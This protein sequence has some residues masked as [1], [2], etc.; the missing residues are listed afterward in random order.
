MHFKY[1]FATLKASRAALMFSQCPNSREKRTSCGRW[2]G[3]SHLPPPPPPPPPAA[4]G[5]GSVRRRPSPVP[6]RA[7][8]VRYKVTDPRSLSASW[9]YYSSSSTSSSS[10]E[11]S[12]RRRRHATHTA[13][14]VHHTRA[15]QGTRAATARR[16]SPVVCT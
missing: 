2:E 13:M 14:R 7:A 1:F 10:Y 9:T 3:E 15:Q 4:R 12:A 5:E 16:R 6:T 8:A 11:G